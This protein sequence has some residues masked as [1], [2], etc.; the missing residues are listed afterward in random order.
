MTR[1]ASMRAGLA[2]LLATS[3]IGLTAAAPGPASATTM[4]RTPAWHVEYRQPGTQITAV[5]ATG[6]DNAWAIGIDRRHG[7]GLLLHWNG[8]HWQP[9]HYRGEA[10]DLP[11]AIFALSA[12]DFWLFVQDSYQALHW[13]NG[14][15]TGLQMPVAGSPMAVV[16]DTNIWISGGDLPNCY[17]SSHSGRGCT[18][19][20]HW[21]GATWTTYPLAAQTI[22]SVSASSRA[23]VWLVGES[24]SQTRAGPHREGY[25]TTSLPYVYRWTG[26]AWRR[27]GLAVRRTS[28]GPS[29]VADSPTKAFVAEASAA[30]PTACAMRWDGTEWKPLYRPGSR[31]ACNWAVSDD[32]GG[33]WLA[34]TL[35]PGIDFLHWTGKRFVTTRRFLPSRYFSTSGFSLAAVP[36]SS[37]VWAFGSYCSLPGA[38]R[39]EGLIER[40][41]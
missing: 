13:S 30:H 5:S 8:S 14:Q 37:A 10:A 4:S 17:V 20:S 26:S 2:A 35:G 38:C 32:H 1:W 36:H 25:T 3:G 40:L 7:T 39:D 12:T 18:A 22:A 33:L 27:S 6:P 29:I 41:D 28:A 34:G 24:Y 31:G 15:W 21:N 19:T 16:S 11:I 9:M 23:G